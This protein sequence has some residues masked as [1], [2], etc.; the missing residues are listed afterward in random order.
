MIR[1]RLYA[2]L[3][4]NTEINSY[5]KAAQEGF[6]MILTL[7]NIGKVE[8]AVVELNGITVI[9]GEN[10]TGKST[11]GRAL[12]SVFNGFYEIERNIKRERLENV[13]RLLDI[14]YHNVTERMT[15]RVDTEEIAHAI[16][17]NSGKYQND[18]E[19]LQKDV[20]DAIS[21]SDSNFLNKAKSKET[22]N[23]FQ[24]ISDILAVSDEDIFHSVLSKKLDAEF[25]GQIN[26]IFSDKN[27]EITLK[28]KDEIA[29]ISIAS[30][31]IQNISG[32]FRL[33]TEVLYIDD[34]FV[35]DEQR[36]PFFYARNLSYVDH[37]THLQRKLY[38]NTDANIINEI[39]VTNKLDSIYEK[40]NSIC[41]GEIV[42]SKRTSFGYKR[43]NSD[44]ILEV[45]NIS[46][47]LKTFVILKT[48]L[49]NGSLEDNGTIV[50]DEPEIHLHPEWQI[51]FAE[52]IVLIQKEFNMHILLNTH[53]PYFLNAIE[54][55]AAKYQIADR[56]K[57]YMATV[58]DD[59]S[60]I[61]DVSDHV[62]VI[63]QRLA[64]PLQE[65]ENTRWQENG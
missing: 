34:P 54:V 8:S 44:K 33:N 65:L 13:E 55:Y 49:Q 15:M 36:P 48:L 19:L 51:L 1:L 43:A 9:A 6:V 12:F 58:H 45:R 7:K 24:R 60:R 30:N 20:F 11:V 42:R 40:I 53:S 17:D 22:I 4:Y 31:S 62:D 56:C 52:L 29:S 50:L 57:Y 25:N 3:C 27:G 64:R 38:N 21:Q 2:I 35:I 28:I 16:V 5:Y 37:R 26:N 10:N 59:V 47:G 23:E 61:E 41:S 46:T 39:I 18:L 63:Y 14:I 32:Q